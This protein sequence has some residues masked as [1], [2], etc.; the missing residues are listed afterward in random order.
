[1]KKN[2]SINNYIKIK[3]KLYN[4]NIKNL[5][6]TNQMD[7]ELFNSLTNKDLLSDENKIKLAMLFAKQDIETSEILLN[8]LYDYRF[9]KEIRII[10]RTILG[11]KI[12]DELNEK[13]KRVYLLAI[14]YGRK[15]LN[16]SDFESAYDIFSLGKAKTKHP[17]F[18]Y[19]I[20]KTLYKQGRYKSAKY[21]LTKYREFGGE[22][23]MKTLLY[24]GAIAE[25]RGN[26]KETI[27]LY[28]RA[29]QLEEA[30]GNSNHYVIKY[31]MPRGYQKIKK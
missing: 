12:Y 16:E 3:D 11:Q 19:Y 6:D 29:N 4:A 20:G 7:T 5:L 21:Y 24:L 8:E 31:N 17:V 23:T 9:S 18:N 10:K 25:K 30:L 22:K 13:Q 28:D 26:Y 14:K 2:N 27:K 15:F 1:M